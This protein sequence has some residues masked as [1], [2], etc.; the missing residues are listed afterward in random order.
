MPK[1]EE[2]WDQE[3]FSLKWCKNNLLLVG[4]V[5][6]GLLVTT[7]LLVIF[8]LPPAITDM[9]EDRVATHCLPIASDALGIPAGNLVVTGKA[10]ARCWVTTPSQVEHIVWYGFYENDPYGIESSHGQ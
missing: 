5:A 9:T 7:P 3:P 8:L 2:A 1:N 6:V 10:L 4:T